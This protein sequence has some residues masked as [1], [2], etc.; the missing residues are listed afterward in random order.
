M[1]AHR[2][3]DVWFAV[4]LGLCFQSLCFVRIG[5]DANVLLPNQVVLSSVFDESFWR[6]TL[7]LNAALFAGAHA[8]LAATFGLLCWLLARLSIRAWPGALIG[9]KKWTMAWLVFG[10]V[11]LLIE[12]AATYRWSSL[13]ELYFAAVTTERLGISVAKLARAA[14]I[15]AVLATVWRARSSLASLSE[16]PIQSLRAIFATAKRS[17]HAATLVG[18]GIAAGLG[19]V[20]LS[21][22]GKRGEATAEYPN[23]IVIGIDSLRQDIPLSDQ[24][25][26]PNIDAFLK[27]S[28]LFSDAITPLARTFPSWV[29]TLTGREPQ[30]T[31]ALVNLLPRD[32]I[33]TGRTLPATLRNA[34]Y[35]TQYAIDEVRFS[36]IDASYGFDRVV[37]PRIGASDFVLG[38]LNDTPL[39]NLVV[40][41]RLGA[42]LFPTTYANRA[43]ATTYDPDTFVSRLASELTFEGPTFT[44]VHLT[45]PHWPYYWAQSPTR[46]GESVPELRQ[47][48]RNAIRRADDQFEAVLNLFRK[49]GQLDRAIVIVLSDHG[50]AIGLASDHPYSQDAEKVRGM[51]ALGHGT[52]VLSPNQ[53]RVV[54]AVKFFGLD[55]Q[56][57]PGR[58]DSPVSLIDVA[59][60]I[61][62]LLRIEPTDP[63]DGQSLA[64]LLHRADNAEARFVDRIR[65]TQSEFNPRG[66]QPGKTLSASA[67]GAIA[68]FYQVDRHTDRISLRPRVIPTILRDRQYA[69]LRA[70]NLLVAL[71]NAERSSFNLFATER[72]GG[73]LVPAN[74]PAN[75]TQDQAELRAELLRRFPAVAAAQVRVTD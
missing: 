6:S 19:S 42:W 46:S 70:S 13:G 2:S 35:T 60:T 20:V 24:A 63:V 26:T 28:V 10:A 75:L 15:I 66:F 36:N 44:A 45:L 16:R 11:W 30:S 52:S 50:E 56:L 64:P 7:A 17:A 49:H 12:N 39:S 37:T 32:M 23:I 67:L 27:D 29:A 65:F 71:P 1:H 41:T 25:L 58:I 68:D 18:I 22:H 62:D 4:T 8:L 53:Y 43:A 40:N 48:Y 33:Q 34:G 74:D 5:A 69:A 73:L 61:L 21:V 9:C 51:T 47:L 38:T 72:E 55:H 57:S 3:S 54:L 31:G 59:P 14:L